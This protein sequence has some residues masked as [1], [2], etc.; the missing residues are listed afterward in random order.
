MLNQTNRELLVDIGIL[1]TPKSSCPVVGLW[2]LDALEVSNV[3]AG[4]NPG[5]IH[6]HC[7]LYRYGASQAEMPQDH[8]HKEYESTVKVLQSAKTKHTESEMNI[9]SVD[10]LHRFC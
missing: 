4:F 5:T 3:V 8:A 1:F 10:R 2:R 7:M 9:V 6:H